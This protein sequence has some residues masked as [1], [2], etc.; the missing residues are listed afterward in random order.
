LT[1]NLNRSLEVMRQTCRRIP[2]PRW[3]PPAGT[4]PA[5]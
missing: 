4:A 1:L 3:P 5:A 2:A